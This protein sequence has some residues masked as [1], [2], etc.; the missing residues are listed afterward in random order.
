MSSLREVLEGLVFQ[1]V[2][3]AWRYQI[4]TSPVSGT[5][6]GVPTMTVWDEA[7]GSDVTASV[8]TDAC[9]LNGTTIT[10]AI[11]YNLRR[12][13]TYKCRITW[14]VGSGQTRSRYFR[15]RGEL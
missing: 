14:S 12:D 15:V 3:E 8:V 2:D 1:G 10:T 13:H 9:S 11:L 4:D 6:T 7:D 5:A